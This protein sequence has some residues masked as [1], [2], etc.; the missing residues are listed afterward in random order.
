MAGVHQNA[1]LGWKEPEQLP[2]SHVSKVA[3]S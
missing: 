2:T 1:L 3:A